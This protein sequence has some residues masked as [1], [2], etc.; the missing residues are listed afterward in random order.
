MKRAARVIEVISNALSRDFSAGLV[1]ILMVMVMAE[2]V[3]RYVFGRP[4]RIA[5]EIGALML[6]AIAF[7]GLAFTWTEKGHIRTQFII[8]HL[9]A[10]VRNRLRVV[11]L[12]IATA[13]V[14]VLILG[15]YDLWARSH[16]FG[17][18]SS[19][20]LRLPLEWPRLV[21]LIATSLL[22]LVV[23]TDLVKSIK[24][25]ATSEGKEP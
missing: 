18:R 20:W 21:W 4:L 10:R 12:F 17:E 1:F 9:P 23:V 5:D 8:S 11:T 14:P 25:P 22:F 19:S 6:A 24:S 16:Q 13:F 7:I 3:A 15:S 2:V